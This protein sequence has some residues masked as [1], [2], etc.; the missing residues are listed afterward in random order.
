[1]QSNGTTAHAKAATRATKATGWY[2]LVR[3]APAILF[4][5]AYAVL[6]HRYYAGGGRDA[7]N[8]LSDT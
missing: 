2:M 4:T 7:L 1:M 5:I 3:L 8:S 6:E